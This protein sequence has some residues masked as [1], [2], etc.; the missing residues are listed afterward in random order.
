MDVQDILLPLFGLLGGLISLYVDPK[1]QKKRV[2]LI[3]TLALIASG[4]I[5]VNR[6]EAGTRNTEKAND[7]ADIT[8][9]KTDNSSLIASVQALSGKADTILDVLRGRGGSGLIRQIQEST[10]ADADR[11]QLL[12]KVRNTLGPKPTVVYYPKEV[13]GE[14]VKRALEEGGLTVT[15]RTARNATPT[16][17]VWVGDKVSLD[18]AKFVALTLVRAG[19]ALT[20]VNRFA[21]G[22]GAKSLLIEVGADPN[23]KNAPVKSAAD[24]SSLTQIEREQTGRSLEP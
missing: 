15:L 23:L 9:L 3:T 17:A 5:L 22:G 6:Y 24:I 19:V 7:K 4:T 10:A 16:N 18:D 8:G 2:L 13:D 14:V 12:P 21:E 1:D 11:A 20:E